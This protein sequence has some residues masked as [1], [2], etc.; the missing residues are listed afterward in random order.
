[1]STVYYLAVTGW[2]MFVVAIGVAIWINEDWYKT[3]TKMNSEWFDFYKHIIE[4]SDDEVT[5]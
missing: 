2:I 4:E 3:C 1:M 5:E